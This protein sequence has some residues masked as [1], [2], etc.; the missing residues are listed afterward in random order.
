MSVGSEAKDIWI[1]EAGGG[2]EGGM[3]KGQRCG[4]ESLKEGAEVPWKRQRTQVE[5][6]LMKV[7]K[8]RLLEN[9]WWDL[10]RGWVPNS[11][12]MWQGRTEIDSQYR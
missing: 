11:Q 10:G 6:G 3:G 12:R 4:T 7:S 8:A 9:Y 5:N 1:H 2:R